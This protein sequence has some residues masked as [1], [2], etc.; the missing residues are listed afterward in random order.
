MFVCLLSFGVKADF[1]MLLDFEG[2]ATSDIG[3]SGTPVATDLL[4][5]IALVLYTQ[6]KK[7]KG[8]QVYIEGRLQT[9]KWQDQSGTIHLLKYQ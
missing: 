7:G 5:A 8:S 2:S 1:L 3:D 4:S 9:R 6:M